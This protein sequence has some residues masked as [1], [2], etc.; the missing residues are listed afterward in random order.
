M[1]GPAL[2]TDCL[3][4]SQP[5]E[6]KMISRRRFGKG[7]LA[8]TTLLAAGATAGKAVSASG[9][10]VTGVDTHAHIFEKTLKFAAQSRYTP[11][12]DAT[13]TMFLAN[14]DANGLSHGV[15]VQ[16]SFLGTDN[17]YM[18]AGIAQAAPRLKGIAVIEPPI[19]E[20]ELDRLAAQNVVGIRLN[21][22][23]REIPDLAG[24]DWKPLLGSLSRRGWQVEIQDEAKRLPDVLPLLLETDLNLVV[25]HFGR[26]DP[27]LGVEDPGFKYL[28]SLGSTRRVWV[29]LSAPYR[30]SDEIAQAAISPLKDTF[31]IDRLLW[32]SDWPHTQYEKDVRYPTMRARL[33]AW[34]PD[35]TERDAVLIDNPAALFGFP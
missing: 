33:D 22:I 2:A 25:D 26:P 28:L 3:Q 7:F 24:G 21:L 18:L 9:S 5:E 23:G 1:V 4:N 30:L 11:D 32:G 17:A 31:G 16:P 14:L 29:K 8:T 13:V 27:D 20:D 12:Y 10:G 6:K 35:A 34:L 19:T 15:L